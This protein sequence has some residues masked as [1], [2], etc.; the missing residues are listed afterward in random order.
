MD[1][2]TRVRIDKWLWAVRVF[3]TRTAAA[4][5]CKKGRVKIAG[6]PAKP[7]YNVKQGDMITV[8]VPPITR[9]FLVKGLLEKRVSA[10]LAED[11]VQETTPQPEFEKLKMLRQTTLGF[12]EKGAGRPTKK[13]RRVMDRLKP[14]LD[15]F[16]S[17]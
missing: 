8:E 16:I 15:E 11:Y 14:E 5:V 4:E 13:E 1:N 6:L 7:S 10:K 12:R 2:T 17:D 3:K 9:T